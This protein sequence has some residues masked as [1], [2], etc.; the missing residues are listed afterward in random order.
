[1]LLEQKT[2]PKARPYLREL[3]VLRVVTVFSVIAVHVLAKTAFLDTSLLA[4]QIQNAFVTAFHFTRETFMFVTAF[5][6]VYVYYGKPFAL[7][8]FWKR[9]G[10][11][12]VLPYIIWSAIYIWITLPPQTPPHFLHI[13]FWDVLT[14]N[15]SYQLYYILLTIQFYLL[16]PWFLR[17]LRRVQYH[18]WI[19]LAVSFL[20]EIITLYLISTYL[21]SDAFSGNA[22]LVVNMVKDRNVLIYQFYFVLGAMAA[23]YVQQMR[24]LIIRYQTWILGGMVAT[25]LALEVHYVVATTIGQV[26]ISVAVAVLQPI[27]AFY[28]TAVIVFLYWR[29]YRWAVRT[30][31]AGSERNSRLWQTLSNASFGIYLVHPLFLTPLLSFVA[32]LRVWPE[33]GLVIFTWAAATAMSITFCVLLLNIPLFSRLIGRETSIP[34]ILAPFKYKK[35]VLRRMSSIG[36]RLPLHLLARREEG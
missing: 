17:F 22:V 3:D 8:R 30:A 10:L 20:L 15:A 2:T 16:F 29:S 21:Q 7:G 33:V 26:P 11:G 1:M 31:Q 9:R 25:L 18:P 6:L 24:A 5:A 19:T 28:S 4:L 12:V 32:S 13:L 23:L 35:A 36:N 27:M 34:P 14:G